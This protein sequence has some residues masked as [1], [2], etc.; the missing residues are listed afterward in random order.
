[1]VDPI[2]LVRQWLMAS[3]ALEAIAGANARVFGEILPEK[4]DPTSNAGITVSIKGGQ[5]HPE[6]SSLISVDIQVTCW[7]GVN[8]FLLARTLYGAVYDS[9]HG[10]NLVTFAGYG[11]I[12]SSVEMTQ[13]QAVVDPITGWATI[14]GAFHMMVRQDGTVVALQGPFGGDFKMLPFE[15]TTGA[16]GAS[17]GPLIEPDGIA[18]LVMVMPFFLSRYFSLKSIAFEVSTIADA[19]KFAYCGVY[20]TDGARLAFAKFSLSVAQSVLSSPTDMAV[21]LAPGVY[22]ACIGSDSL[23]AAGATAQGFWKTGLM[24]LVAARAANLISAGVMPSTLGALTPDITGTMPSFAL[25]SQ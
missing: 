8:Q 13:G 19:G 18:N 10:Q 4:Y 16:G 11:T 6:I 1:M 3:V 9:L 7:A 24:V 17:A 15:A 25:L 21:L 14:V 5:G 12:V 20:K 23:I 22:Y 2:Q